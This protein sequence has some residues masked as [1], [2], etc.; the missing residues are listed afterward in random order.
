MLRE[1]LRA[2][3]CFHLA[4]A[5]IVAL[6]VYLIANRDVGDPDVWWHMRN[7]QYLLENFKLPNVDM[8]SYTAAGEPWI[9]HQ[10][11][12]EIPYYLAYKIGGLLGLYVLYLA[13]VEGILLGTFYLAYKT[14]GNV[15][16]A[17]LV[18]CFSVLLAAVSFGPRT[19]LFGYVC[20]LVLLFLLY[21]YRAT[22]E[23]PLWVL[24][25]L[26]CLWVNTHG[27]WLFGMIVLGVFIVTGLVEGTWGRIEAV[28]WT[29]QQLRHLLI[30]AGASVAAL[31]VNPYTYK[32]VWYPFDMKLHQTLN[33]GHV[34]EWASVNFHDARG[35]IVLIL[36]AALILG[37]LL[38]RQRWRLEEL[39]LAAMAVYFG[40]THVRFLFQA[41]LLLAPLLARMLD[42]LP[43]YRREID[44]PLLNAVICG[45]VLVIF[46]FRF[47]TQAQLAEAVGRTYPVDA[48]V[49]IKKHG[50]DGPI[51]NLYIWGGYLGWCCPRV[52]N[53]IDS[54]AD[55]YEAKGVFQDYL[56]AITMKGSLEIL[57]KY[58]VRYV[59]MPP[60]APLTYLV[61]NVPGWEVVY[62]DKVT[63]I[64]ERTVL[65]PP[66]S[67]ENVG[68][69]QP[70]AMAPQQG[71]RANTSKSSVFRP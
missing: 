14:S 3:F 66:P 9:N 38:S 29:P 55:I 57:D 35:K 18:G 30:A 48:M 23:S 5:A 46:L 15:K 10:W 63:T 8:Y 16:G 39:A 26:F 64:T 40:L 7:A 36:I 22:G 69:K 24:P 21:R 58:K 43:P 65:L 25:L 33:I 4:L 56:D 27:S 54:R 2:L 19:L 67:P 12:A 68:E 20:L 45:G 60:D 37:A 13:L 52:K 32:L 41:A 1:R 11:L 71:N 44:K 62:S 53:F 31:F 6:W 28:R 51:F 61:K 50:L 17:F 59:V 42:F 47:P 34:E 49:Y 70:A